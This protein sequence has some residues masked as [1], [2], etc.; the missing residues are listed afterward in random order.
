MTHRTHVATTTAVAFPLL[1]LGHCL[2]VF[3]LG[4]I[5]IGSLLP[6]IDKRGSY[7]SKFIPIVPGILEHKFGHRGAVHSL[8]ATGVIGIIT[9]I[10]ALLR[11][12]GIIHTYIPA[13]VLFGITIGF[14]LHLCE[15]GLSVSGIRWFA[16][17]KNKSY[18]ISDKSIFRFLKYKTLNFSKGMSKEYIYLYISLALILVELFLFKSQLSGQIKNLI[19][20][21]QSSIIPYKHH[22]HRYYY[23]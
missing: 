5:I 6:D 15:D 10:L 16:P 4:G 8:A 22:Y 11:V 19:L 1:E 17:F 18:K 12:L 14:F 3:I 7:I 2:N 23:N 21:G 9:I 20:H 13:I